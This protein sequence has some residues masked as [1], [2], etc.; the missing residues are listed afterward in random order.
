MRRNRKLMS[1]VD[2]YGLSNDQINE[3]IENNLNQS[4]DVVN[5]NSLIDMTHR[6]HIESEQ[7]LA[8]E[9]VNNDFSSRSQLRKDDGGGFQ[10]NVFEEKKIEIVRNSET[11]EK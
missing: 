3:I 11:E 10:E 1:H 4:N 5:R 9:M 7:S 8:S 6:T 2:Q